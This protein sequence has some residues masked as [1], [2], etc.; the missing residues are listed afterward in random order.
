MSALTSA[1]PTMSSVELVDVINSMREDGRAELL[2]KNFIVKIESHPGIHSAK[3]LAQ[4]KDATGRTLKCY[5]LPKREAELMVMSESLAVQAKVYDRMTEWEIAK[6]VALPQAPSALSSAKE[7]KAL[8]SIAKLIGM[9][10]NAA[11]ISAN[12]GVEKLTGTNVLA[13]LGHVQLEA[14]NQEA[15]FYTP[16]ELGERKSISAR[17]LNLLLAEA[18]L[19]MKRGDAWEVLDA[20]RAFAR[21]YDTG[22]KHGSGVPIQQIKWA[23]T[24]L[25]VLEQGAEA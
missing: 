10:K 24:V 3:F 11:A 1:A 6:P 25:P 21:I 5:Q 17:K 19:Q 16:T 4:Y 14:E 8:F 13:L 20:G 7:F 2:H 18:G 23:A 12:Q 9:D 22:K 15:Q